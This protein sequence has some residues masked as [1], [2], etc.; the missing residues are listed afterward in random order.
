LFLGP[1]SGRGGISLHP[2]GVER[3]IT[4]IIYL[5]HA[6]DLAFLT[7]FVEKVLWSMKYGFLVMFKFVD[8]T[9]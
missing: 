8:L 3:D 5:R 7:L 1:H 4:I 2:N 9:E 6:P